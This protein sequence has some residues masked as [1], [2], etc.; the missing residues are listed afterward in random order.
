MTEPLPD[1]WESRELPVLRTVV[2][3]W[4]TEQ[5]PL[6][7][8]QIK[9]ALPTLEPRDV[10]RALSALLDEGIIEGQ[11]WGDGTVNHKIRPRRG[12]RALAGSWPTAETGVER[13][14]T[15]LENIA[16]NTDDEE[17]RTRIQQF[18]HFLSSSGKQV[19]LSVVTAVLT[20]QVT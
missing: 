15:A 17:E 9:S 19:G 16:E 6:A 4:D 3:I 11:R 2:Q 12:A 13:L 1:T 10:E 14:I 5:M 20:G 8:G 18:A 7:I